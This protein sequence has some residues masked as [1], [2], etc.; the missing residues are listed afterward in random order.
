MKYYIGF[1]ITIVFVCTFST[2]QAQTL[3]IEMDKDTI[4]M[5]EQIQVIYKIDKSC[6]GSELKFKD[7]IVVAGPFTSK[8][9]SIVNGKRTSE[10]TFTFI[11]TAMK[12]GTF[13]LPTELCGAKLTTPVEIVAIQGYESQISKDQRIRKARK[14]RKI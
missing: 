12:E 6:R 1:I 10:S 7:L 3:T 2:L 14:I 9:V 13:Q 11:L 8:S 4:S 5:E